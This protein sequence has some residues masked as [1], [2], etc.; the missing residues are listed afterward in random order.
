MDG[1]VSTV[2]NRARFVAPASATSVVSRARLDHRYERATGRVLRVIA[3]GGYGKST[4]VARWVAGEDRSV[5]WVDLERIDNDPVVLAR[6]VSRAIE[7]LSDASAEQLWSSPDGGGPLDV[8]AVTRVLGE[9]LASHDRPFL[10]VLDDVHNVDG[11]ESL[12]VIDAIAAQ[13]PPSSTLV[14]SGRA[15]HGTARIG[16][17][18][19]TPG[20]IDVGTDDLA[21]DAAETRELL[22]SMGLDVDPDQ[23]AELTGH[24]EGWPAGLRLTALVMQAGGRPLP[25]SAPELAGDSTYVVDYLRSEWVGF[26]PREDLRFLSEVACL[27]RVTGEMCDEV[28]GHAGS[29]ATLRRLHRS[30][31]LVLPLDRR[32]KWFRMHPLLTRWLSSELKEANPER[33]REV[34]LRAS[35]WWE[36]RGDV[37]LA[38]EHARAAGDLGLAEALVT[39][40]GGHYL[41]RGL[42]STVHRWLQAFPVES[43]R[44]SAS[45]CSACTVDALIAGDGATARRWLN[46][47]ERVDGG[48]EALDQEREEEL[49]KAD[50]L[51]AI[52]LTQPSEALVGRA[53]RALLGLD[54]GPWYVMATIALCGLQ[55]LRGDLEGAAETAADG[56]F[57][58]QLAGLTVSG[59]NSTAMG[60]IVAD[61]AG[62]TRR[63]GEAAR[64]ASNSLTDVRT[65]QLHTTAVVDAVTALVEARTGRRDR[66]AEEM[67]LARAKLVGYADIGPWYNVVVRLPLIGT[68]LLLDDRQA[69]RELLREVDHHLRFEPPDHGVAS[70]LQALRSRV[71]AAGDR[72]PD[73]SWS[74]T[75]AELKVMS[76][77]PTNLSLGDIADRLFLSRN[78]VKTHVSAIYRKLGTSSRGEAVEMARRAGLVET[79]DW[80]RA[81]AGTPPRAARPTENPLRSRATP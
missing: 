31:D 46:V 3:P 42:R 49:A 37:D 20:V 60:A 56:A 54:G 53:E 33:W 19:L 22:G 63:A 58:A 75:P 66:A 15:H 45:L 36:E 61:L 21:L 38:F 35:A 59:A 28:L 52:I 65:D 13:L 18:R 14:L 16:R 24:F 9:I 30:E 34:H 23:L 71:E 76:H 7:Q 69:G 6:A 1:T 79:G 80:N 8:E 51:R 73:P 70:H 77:L 67:A 47:L 48:D 50:A 26:L 44:S 4:L 72:H 5:G 64:Q 57:E 40:H 39:G 74:L 55:I 43:L 17:L 32:D 11:D 68:A 62:D 27:E 12:A 81:A 29:A 78:T 10:L 41:S 2:R 25:A